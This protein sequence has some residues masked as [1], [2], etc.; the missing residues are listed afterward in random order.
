MQSKF[1]PA[2]APYPACMKPILS[3]SSQRG[4]K[5][6]VLTITREEIEQVRLQ[7]ALS[8]VRSLMATPRLTVCNTGALS[9]AIDGY[10]AGERAQAVNRAQIRR[11]FLLLDR[12]FNGWFHL[13]NRWD[14]SLR[15]L[16]LSMACLKESTSPD[17]PGLVFDVNDLQLFI[18]VHN[19]AMTRI[20]LQSGI[21]HRIT[22]HT[23]RLMQAYFDN[24][25]VTLKKEL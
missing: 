2:A 5:P 11:Y 23:K 8:L 16:F 24:C 13:C 15:M 20:H 25:F 7:P 10:A 18:T 22:A 21:P 1:R 14:N 17:K 19:M 9:L 12:Q 3:L 4:F 6:I